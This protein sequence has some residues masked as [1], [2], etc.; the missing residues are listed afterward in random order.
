MN[1]IKP[2]KDKY[3]I[4]LKFPNRTC[5]KCRKYPC[6]DGISKCLSDFAKHGCTYYSEL[7]EDQT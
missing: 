7:L 3:G 4:K 5:K 6:F 1:S 2:K